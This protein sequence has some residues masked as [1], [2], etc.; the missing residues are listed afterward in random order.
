MKK[1]K[2]YLKKSVKLYKISKKVDKIPIYNINKI[3]N[4]TFYTYLGNKKRFILDNSIII[5]IIYIK[6][7]L[8]N[9]KIINKIVK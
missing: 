2:K 4:Y 8:I 3:K 6:N 7:N 9:Y 1:V 5:Y